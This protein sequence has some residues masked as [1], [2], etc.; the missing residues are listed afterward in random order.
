[1][2]VYYPEVSYMVVGLVVRVGV[3]VRKDCNQVEDLEE[4]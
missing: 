4:G 1:M 2:G 3:V